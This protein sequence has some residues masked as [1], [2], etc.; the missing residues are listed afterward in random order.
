MAKKSLSREARRLAS[1]I[2]V[3]SME[4]IRSYQSNLHYWSFF[5]TESGNFSVYHADFDL[6]KDDEAIPERLVASS[7][8]KAHPSLAREVGRNMLVPVLGYSHTG[9]LQVRAPHP[10]TATWMMVDAPEQGEAIDERFY[11]PGRTHPYA[12][13]ATDALGVVFP[14]PRGGTT[15]EIAEGARLVEEVASLTV[16]DRVMY[17]PPQEYRYPQE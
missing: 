11:V 17:L 9:P 2:A 1:P 6:F 5:E 15:S 7:V 10:S 16:A 3:T 12:F 8:Y 4:Q 13:D 14:F